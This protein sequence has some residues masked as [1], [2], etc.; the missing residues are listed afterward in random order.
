MVFL[1]N[2]K[3]FFM[4]KIHFLESTPSTNIVA[5]TMA[6]DGAPEGVAVVAS[7]QSA[8]RGRLGKTWFSAAGLGLYCSIIVRPRL[9]AVDY[10]KITLAA[11]VAV[12]LVLDRLTGGN[13]QLK[14]PNDIYFSGKKCGGILTESSPL[15]STYS[16]NYAIVGIGVNVNNRRNDFPPELCDQVTSLRL[17]TNKNYVIRELFGEIRGELLRQVDLLSRGGFPN[18]LTLWREKDFLLG[19]RMRCVG[20]DH[21]VLE[22]VALGPDDEGVLHVKDDNAIRHRVLSGDVGLARIKQP[23][24]KK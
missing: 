16:C 6:E 12:A 23:A 18:I 1:A 20:M 5:R 22:G 21:S 17:E 8:G 9:T 14:W 2:P 24:A 19:K 3:K 10:P 11:G 7:S 4:S 13:T 15:S